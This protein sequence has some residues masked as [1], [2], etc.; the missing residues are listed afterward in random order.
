VDSGSLPPVDLL[1]VNANGSLSGGTTPVAAWTDGDA[2]GVPR[3]VVANLSPSG[4]SA[5]PVLPVAGGTSFRS[6]SL[7]PAATGLAAIAYQDA[8]SGTV[9]AARFCIPDAG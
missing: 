3:L 5:P 8:Q 6:L 9:Y 2:S 7:A 4:R 1:A